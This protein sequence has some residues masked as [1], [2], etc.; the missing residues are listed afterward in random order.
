ML[1]LFGV[2]VAE[3][4]LLALIV[5]GIVIHKEYFKNRIS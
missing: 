1:V 4:F 5:F 3:V 2:L